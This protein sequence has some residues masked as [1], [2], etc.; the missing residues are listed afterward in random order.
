MYNPYPNHAFLHSC[1]IDERHSTNMTDGIVACVKDMDTGESKLHIIRNPKTRI[2]ILREGLRTFEQPREYVRISDCDTYIVGYRTQFEEIWHYLNPNRRMIPQP[3]ICR[4]EVESS[5][6]TFGW[7][8]SPQIRM[9]CE[10]LNETP[11][12]PT[13]IKLAVLDIETCVLEENRDAIIALS[14]CDWDAR[15]VHCFIDTQLWLR[16]LDDKEL[17]RRTKIAYGEFVE[18]L[19]AKA[20][21]IWDEKPVVP[22]YYRCA[23]ERELLIKTFEVLHRIKPD[24]LAVWNL[25]FDCPTIL[26]RLAFQQID[27]PN[28]VCHP[29]VPPEFRFAEWHED[30]SKVAHFTDV[31]HVLDAPGYTY[32]YDAMAL[33][34]RIRKVQGRDIKYSL[35]YIGNKII[36]SGKMHFGSNQSHYLMQT[37]DKVGYCVY[38][39]IDTLIPAL[40]NA[41]T[42]DLSTMLALADCSL[43]QDF[44]RQTVQLTAQFYTYLMDQNKIPG[45]CRGSIRQETDKFIGNIGGAVLDPIRMRVRGIPAVAESPKGTDIYKLASDLDVSSFYPSMTIAANVSRETKVFTTLWM[46]GCPYTLEQI[47]DEP[48]EKRQ[49]EMARENAEH[50]YT[51]FGLLPCVKENAVALCHN[52]FGLPN[53]EEILKLFKSQNG[54]NENG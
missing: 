35:D 6:Y 46:D 7:N 27:I 25:G 17:E 13:N 4:K 26:N 8:I 1:Y 23:G 15:V 2:Y 33:Y 11:K 42:Q 52:L 53:Y 54:E 29:D 12:D 18:G 49:D 48:D 31:W 9:K 5:P 28:T 51:V 20:R 47:E 24:F 30:K 34:A 3:F 16:D 37:N 38:N 14:I 43:I 36:G 41:V 32:W 44:S 39:T 40:M 45:A 50:V 22:V 10:Y 19:N 21:K